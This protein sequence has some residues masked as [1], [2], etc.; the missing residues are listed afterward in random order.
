MFW[1][2]FSFS[3]A[4]IIISYLL[5]FAS[6]VKL[7]ITDPN[8]HRPFKVPGGMPVAVISA[9]LCMVFIFMCA[10]LFIFPE[11]PK[12]LVNWEHSGPILGGVIIVL[13]VGDVIIRKAEKAHAQLKHSVSNKASH[14]S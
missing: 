9:L 5:F 14:Q 7:R 3:S 11:L 10:V 2:V 4:C 1:S 13:V 8:T 6:F 12:G